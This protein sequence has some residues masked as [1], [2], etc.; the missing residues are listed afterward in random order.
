MKMMNEKEILRQLQ[1]LRAK[2]EEIESK[3]KDLPMIVD[4][5]KM[6]KRKRSK[7]PAYR[8]ENKYL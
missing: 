7:S 3:I 6:I 1:D 5:T 8:K 4:A 2:V